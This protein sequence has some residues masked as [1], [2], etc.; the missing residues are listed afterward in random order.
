MTTYLKYLH[1]AI[2]INYKY[3]VVDKEIQAKG[4]YNE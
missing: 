3:K 4:M 1:V 2:V